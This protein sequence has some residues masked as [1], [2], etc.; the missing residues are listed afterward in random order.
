MLN[1]S[2]NIKLNAT[3]DIIGGTIS[4]FTFTDN[5]GHS[6]AASGLTLNAL[7]FYN[8]TDPLS[9]PDL[10]GLFSL[11]NDPTRLAGN[12]TI[13]GGDGS[14]TINGF[15]GNDILGGGG[16]QRYFIGRFR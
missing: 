11:V 10:A 3:D 9:H 16:R 5:L 6:F 14:D 8:I 7:D 13:T 2:G 4:S 12:D 1:M 15:A